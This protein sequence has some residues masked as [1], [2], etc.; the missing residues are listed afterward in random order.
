MGFIVEKCEAANQKL[1]ENASGI[2]V[3]K[4]GIVNKAWKVGTQIYP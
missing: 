3:Q 2:T 1:C 4:L